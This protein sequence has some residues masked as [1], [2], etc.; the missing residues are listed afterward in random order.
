MTIINDV[1]LQSIIITKPSKLAYSHSCI[2][3]CVFLLCL[4]LAGQDP[5]KLDLGFNQLH[6]AST[7][8]ATF[9]LDITSK[10]F[11]RKRNDEWVADNPR[12]KFEVDG[13]DG[14]HDVTRAVLNTSMLSVIIGTKKTL[15]EDV[16]K[17]QRGDSLQS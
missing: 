17:N 1:K 12:V 5:V 2:A 8:S 13:M 16:L 10:I 14:L 6:V 4:E 3:K 7:P 15:N 9:P 11:L